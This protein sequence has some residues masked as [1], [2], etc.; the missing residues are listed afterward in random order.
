MKLFFSGESGKTNPEIVLGDEAMIMLTF[1]DYYGK[2]KLKQRFRDI[3]EKRLE[4]N[5]KRKKKRG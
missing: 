2:K 3:Y 5:K 1:N 4:C